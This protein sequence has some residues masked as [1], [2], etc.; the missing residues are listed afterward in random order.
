MCAM[1]NI[2]IYIY[3]IKPMDCVMFQTNFNLPVLLIEST[4]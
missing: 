3:A 2:H 1:R 4:K